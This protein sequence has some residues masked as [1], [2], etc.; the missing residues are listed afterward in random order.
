MFSYDAALAKNH[1]DRLSIESTGRA[2][3]TSSLPLSSPDDEL[4]LLLPLLRLIVSHLQGPHPHIMTL[5]DN[6]APLLR[7]KHNLLTLARWAI[8][9]IFS[10]LPIS[11][12]YHQSNYHLHASAAHNTTCPPD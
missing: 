5:L 2:T 1:T 8:L 11:P 7:T 9:H 6:P 4:L 10:L 3:Q 12:S